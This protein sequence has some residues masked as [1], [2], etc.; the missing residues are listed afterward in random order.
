MN[1]TG[2]LDM[3]D[4][5]G[6]GAAGNTFEG[7]PLSGLLN[8][9]GVKPRGYADRMAEAQGQPVAT[10]TQNFAQALQGAVEQAQDRQQPPMQMPSGPAGVGSGAQAPA[11][12]YQPVNGGTPHLPQDPMTPQMPQSFVGFDGAQSPMMGQQR[13]QDPR[14]AELE[15]YLRSVGAM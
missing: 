11:P 12:M 1:F 10:S 7:G 14:Q 9:I 6:A 8:I 4:G 2:L 13:P 15:A 5:G 3:I